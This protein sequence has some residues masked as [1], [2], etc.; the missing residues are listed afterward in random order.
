MRYGEGSL[1]AASLL[2]FWDGLEIQG[3]IRTFFCPCSTE[4][5][6][7]KV[8]EIKMKPFHRRSIIISLVSS[9]SDSY[10]FDECASDAEKKTNPQVPVVRPY[11]TTS[12]THNMCGIWT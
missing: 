6:R 10:L 1:P 9:H 7:Q 12:Q 5:Q 4:G 2:I 3:L 8:V 11:C